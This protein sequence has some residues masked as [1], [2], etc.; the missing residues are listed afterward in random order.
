[1]VRWFWKRWSKYLTVVTSPGRWYAAMV[2]KH[3]MAY[4]LINY[5]I[6]LPDSANGKRPADLQLVGMH[7]PNKS[8]KI[9]LKRRSV[10]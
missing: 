10:E 6:K 3:V 4:L 7:L 2:I 5:D 9:L 8:A 1:M